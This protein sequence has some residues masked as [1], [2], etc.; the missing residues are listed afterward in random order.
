M[1]CEKMPNYIVTGGAGYIGSHL[2]DKL[3]SDSLPSPSRE[4]AEVAILDDLSSSCHIN[5]KAKLVKIDLRDNSKTRGLK[6]N[7]N[8]IIFH[9]ACN[10]DVKSSM[11]D[12]L[13][14]Y[15]RDVTVTLN[16]LELARRLDAESFVFTSSSTVYGDATTL[17]T[18]EEYPL[19]P[20]SNYGLYKVMGEELVKYY[21]NNYGIK[22]VIFRVANVVGG[23][24]SHGVLRN[25]TNS[26]RK[27]KSRLEILGDGKQTKS[28]IYISDMLTA[29]RKFGD[30]PQ[31]GV[32]ILNIGSE[33]NI[34]L[35]EIAGIVER[36]MGA[37][38]KHIFPNN[39]DGRGW[40]GDVRRFL[41]D[42]KKITRLG[43]K[44]RYNSREAVALAVDDIL[45]EMKLDDPH[46]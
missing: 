39:L 43:W 38:P 42:I 13:D 8:P 34:S 35:N 19:K 14:H 25:F 32:S 21:A 6:L 9:L 26:L 1:R 33:D 18:P 46:R 4:T 12:K 27:D 37:S 31:K 24:T 15:S 36:K 20:I 22:S 41:L 44:P 40:E 23:R 45:T 30:R 28:Y 10:P 17:P 16:A 29:L 5:R 3:L 7:R 11:V 2:V